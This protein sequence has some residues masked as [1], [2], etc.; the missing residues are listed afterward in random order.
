MAASGSLCP[1]VIFP[2]PPPPLVWLVGLGEAALNQNLVLM[3][4]LR[5]AGLVCQMAYGGSM[6]SQMRA[7]NH[8]GAAWAV[9]RGDD[10]LAAGVAALKDLVS[11][12]Q[13]TC[14]VDQ[15]A[16]RIEAPAAPKPA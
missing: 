7:A 11:G 2:E 16:G 13:E 3:Q 10:E 8:S 6:K 5:A 1:K 15:V 12:R 14:P 9:I 4:R